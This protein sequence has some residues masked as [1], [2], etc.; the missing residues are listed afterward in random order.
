MAEYALPFALE[1]PM[2][3]GNTRISFFVYE[4]LFLEKDQCASVPHDHS[5]Y[6]LF[7]AV[8][9]E[10]IQSIE[11]ENVRYTEGDLVLIR[12]YEYHYQAKETLSKE[13]SRYSFR[14][15]I[16]P[17]AKSA[18]PEAHRGYQ[19]LI[20][21]FSQTRTLRDESGRLLAHFQ[22]L[23]QE[24]TQKEVGYFC[25][26][27]GE[28]LILFTE[29]LRLSEENCDAVYPSEELRHADYFRRQIERFLR[30]RLA[31]KVTLDDLASALCVSTRQTTRLVR[32]TFGM[33][34]VAKL[35][36]V[37]IERA[38]FLLK[39]GEM[40]P[41]KIAAECGFQSYSYFAARFRD[42]VGMTPTAYKK[43]VRQEQNAP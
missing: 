43:E 19:S 29:I 40:P 16:H 13:I 39:N 15:S 22:K 41:D 24:I 28:C 14:F 35:N 18:S 7:Y 42:S 34:F 9:G 25:C 21:L 6:E 2:Q 12:P 30:W 26:I 17:P 4:N 27:Q 37:R 1:I 32:R 20:S 3:V 31:E 8:T 11:D 23:H 38:K 36:Q 5:D 10:G 33:S